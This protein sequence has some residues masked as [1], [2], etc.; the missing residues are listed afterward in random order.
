MQ[1]LDVQSMFSVENDIH[2]PKSARTG[3]IKVS[4][5]IM[6]YEGK[7]FKISFDVVIV[8]KI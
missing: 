1:N 7:Y 2:C 4:Q 3:Y 5:C 8:H 6:T